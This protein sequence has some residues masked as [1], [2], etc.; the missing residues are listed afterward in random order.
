M[1]D[2]ATDH[3]PNVEVPDASHQLIANFDRLRLRIL[4]I[5]ERRWRM[6]LR[7]SGIVRSGQAQVSQIAVSDQIEVVGH[8]AARTVVRAGRHELARSPGDHER[9]VT[10]VIESQVQL[11][12]AQVGQVVVL[13]EQ[14]ETVLSVRAN[15]ERTAD[16][17]QL[18]PAFA[19]VVLHV[20]ERM[21]IPLDVANCTTARLHSGRELP[22]IH[23]VGVR[24]SLDP[25][26]LRAIHQDYTASFAH[27]VSFTWLIG[28]HK[29]SA[30]NLLITSR[31]IS[32]T[33]KS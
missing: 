1:E 23:L 17:F 33:A 30:F 27:F 19:L 26:V 11:V 12:A 4:A 15:H 25:G 21:L 14:I 32:P 29:I 5:D 20:L 10:I 31:A 2:T 16:A 22:V 3:W 9:H 7:H 8:P 18:E 6:D 13:D 28:D 24:I